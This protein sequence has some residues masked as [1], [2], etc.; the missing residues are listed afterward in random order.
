MLLVV[1]TKRTESIRGWNNS[2][3][4]RR[5]DASLLFSLLFL[6]IFRNS[7][8]FSLLPSSLFI[9]FSTDIYVYIHTHTLFDNSLADDTTR[10]APRSATD[11][12][13]FTIAAWN[14]NYCY[15]RDNSRRCPSVGIRVYCARQPSGERDLQRERERERER[16]SKLYIGMVYNNG[17]LY[18]INVD[19]L[20]RRWPRLSM[21]RRSNFAD[22]ISRQ[23]TL[24][25]QVRF[26][27]L[28]PPIFLLKF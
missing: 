6:S 2:R 11:Q 5:S 22:V 20:T 9:V 4:R 16:G 7:L 1:C 27:A 10:Q 8:P 15:T 3:T 25:P 12:Y 14:D 24:D 19:V 13:A 21:S 23:V 18:F 28:G 26:R 17:A